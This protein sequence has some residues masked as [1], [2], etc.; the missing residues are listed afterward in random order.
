MSK[1]TNDGLFDFLESYY[2]CLE[3]EFYDRWD[4]WDKTKYSE[5]VYEVIG[6]LISRQISLVVQLLKAPQIWCGNIA[7]IILRSMCDVHIRFVWVTK[8]PEERAIR[9]I[10]YGLGREKLHI[11]HME[12]YIREHEDC[13]ELEEILNKMGEWLTPQRFRFL[14]EVDLG[15][16]SG[17]S[18]RKMAEE[19]GCLDLYNYAFSPFSSAVH[20]EWN[21][22]GKHN[23][24]ICPNPLHGLHRVPIT[25]DESPSIDYL[26]RSVKYVNK[27]LKHFDEFAEI[28]T[29]KQ[30][31][32]NYF[33]ENVNTISTEELIH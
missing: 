20:S 2:R 30:S 4:N 15:N 3:E 12:K 33:I 6:G 17:M 26:Y 21:H 29:K 24:I 1:R 22:I 23:L 28:S 32:F 10:R 14:T 16:M 7:P 31:A 19:V 13:T 25:H 8:Q 11:E 9:Y 18:T 27:T 5:E